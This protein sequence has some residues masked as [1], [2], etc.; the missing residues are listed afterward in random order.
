[1]MCGCWLQASHTHP[2]MNVIWQ[3]I[4]IFFCNRKCLCHLV[5]SCSFAMV[6]ICQFLLK[7]IY[8][9]ASC[10]FNLPMWHSKTWYSW[11][12]KCFS[13][14]TGCAFVSRCA[15]YHHYSWIISFRNWM[16][17]WIG[18]RRRMAK[19]EKSNDFKSA[20]FYWVFNLLDVSIFH[21]SFILFVISSKNHA[22]NR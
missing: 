22:M 1:M 6:S 14:V 21:H 4:F 20:V 19:G 7:S 15:V 3:N 2:H 5:I 8:F 16:D 18:E 12:R 10:W 9:P 17:G 13:D 11:K